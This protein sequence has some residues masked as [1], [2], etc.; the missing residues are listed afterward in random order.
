MFLGNYLLLCQVTSLNAYSDVVENEAYFKK[1][2]EK[3]KLNGFEEDK[4]IAVLD[5]G[6]SD[7]FELRDKMIVKYD[8]TTNSIVNSEIH[9]I[10]MNI[11]TDKGLFS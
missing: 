10:K 7:N 9:G 6:I 2:I 1:A 3:F 8:L 5:I 4:T 11:T